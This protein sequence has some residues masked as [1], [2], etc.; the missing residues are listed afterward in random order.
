M[1]LAKP[2]TALVTRNS[3]QVIVLLSPQL[4]FR[5]RY[6]STAYSLNNLLVFACL[7]QLAM[8]RAG[9]LKYQQYFPKVNW[10]CL[11]FQCLKKAL[12]Y[13]AN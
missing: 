10:L 1:N 12:Q 13:L 8:K 5:N 6:G 9:V 2:D 7:N 4:P 11:A 3:T